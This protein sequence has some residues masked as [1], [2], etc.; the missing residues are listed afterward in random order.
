MGLRIRRVVFGM[1]AHIYVRRFTR[2]TWLRCTPFRSQNVN[3]RT[4]FDGWNG[5]RR[6]NGSA[7]R[8]IKTCREGYSRGSM[9]RAKPA[10]IC[11]SIS[12]KVLIYS[13]LRCTTYLSYILYRN[14]TSVADKQASPC[15]WHPKSR[16]IIALQPFMPVIPTLSSASSVSTKSPTTSCH[17]IP[18]MSY[19]AHGAPPCRTFPKLHPAAFGQLLLNGSSLCVQKIHPASSDVRSTKPIV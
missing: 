19:T 11:Q 10:K 13:L 2:L 16:P 8:C 15:R 1:F 14:S 7:F 12:I 9:K 18:T 6:S 5:W 17:G 3:V 4:R